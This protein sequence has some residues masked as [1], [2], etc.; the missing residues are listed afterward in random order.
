[1]SRTDG[2]YTAVQR[3]LITEI[4]KLATSDN[5]KNIV[6]AFEL[7]E[8]ITPDNHKYEMRFVRE[9]VETDH[10]A[11]NIARHVINLNPACRDGFI[12]AFVFNCL[13][14]G[15]QK[16]Q[17]F[18]KRTGIPTPF[19]VLMSPTMRCNLTCEGCYAADYSPDSDMT[20]ELMQSIVD[21]ANDMGV[22]LFTILG[23][24]P[25]VRDD[26]LDF[27]AAN[28]DAYFQ[29]YT[30]GTLLDDEAIARMAEIGNVAPMLSIEGDE[31]TTD[32]RR[33]HGVYKG[34][35][36]AMDKLH[37]AGVLFGYSATVTK[38]NWS[39]LVSDEF[40]DPLVAKGAS[41]SWH[42]LYMPVGRDPDTSLM[43][44]PTERNEFRL[45]IDRIRSTKAMFPI[46]FWGDA[47]WVKGCIAGKHYIHINNEGWVEPCIFCHFATHNVKESTL[48]EA[49][50][51]P[52]FAEIRRRQPFN[53]NLLMP[54]MLIDNPTMSREIVAVTGAHPTHD[55][56]EV[57]LTELRQEL[58]QYAAEVERVYDPIWSCLS[59]KKPED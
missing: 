54:C 59:G 22:Y 38:K 36:E 19:V 30:N 5:K 16:R 46:D 37:D 52:F 14:R 7:A 3:R 27:C 51:A 49:F 11:L 48:A 43:L 41:I 4:L 12:N 18:N 42:F 45:G 10:P 31:E 44:T 17:D 50:G 20:T 57:M 32:A 53:H 9:K 25:F 1:M 24:E 26:L 8:R 15:S 13:L 47:P 28:S 6:R 33:G 35:M 21:Q 34:L 40:V 39:M 56:A 55:G 29:I 23:G 58:D 2:L